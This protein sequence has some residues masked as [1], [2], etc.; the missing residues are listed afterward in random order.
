MLEERLQKLPVLILAGGE[1][2]P[3]YKLRQFFNMLFYGERFLDYKP[4]ANVRDK[5]MLQH[6][7]DAFNSYDRTAGSAYIIGPRELGEAR[8]KRA[9]T[10]FKEHIVYNGSFAQNIFVGLH[11]II[12]KERPELVLISSCDIPRLSPAAI[13]E[14]VTACSAR[15]EPACFYGAVINKSSIAKKG[16]FGWRPAIRCVEGR[17]RLVNLAAARIDEQMR[18]L[19]RQNYV[20]ITEQK[21]TPG[22]RL[23][24]LLDAGHDARRIL[25]PYNVKKLIDIVREI[26]PGLISEAWDIVRRSY[27][28]YLPGTQPGASLYEFENLANRLLS[29]SGLG[30][31][32]KLVVTSDPGAAEDVDSQSDLAI[33]RG[34][35]DA[36]SL[37]AIL[38][39]SGLGIALGYNALERASGAAAEAALGLLFLVFA[40]RNAS[41]LYK[42]YR[43]N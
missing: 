23:A 14:F 39:E 32:L 34:R 25:N 33:E 27:R 21:A 31:R 42:A 15:D 3:K 9:L 35:F 41:L 43:R 8:R 24:E 17:F 7:I 37:A 22:A 13:E 6:V 38:L 28:A 26:S 36:A 29:D 4:L 18:E 20:A 16:R 12:E 1:R 30:C 11:T 10:G 40:V 5:P 2:R 19:V